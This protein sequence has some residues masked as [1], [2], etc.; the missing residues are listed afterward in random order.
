ML[1]DIQAP[2]GGGGDR[3][4]PQHMARVQG[5]VVQVRN[6]YN[7]PY[8]RLKYI[9]KNYP[10]EMAAFLCVFMGKCVGASFFFW[11]G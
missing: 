6:K 1:R 11:G 2:E 8:F 10:V 4:G 7:F 9:L 3:H 5:N